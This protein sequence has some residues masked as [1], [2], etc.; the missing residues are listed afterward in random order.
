MAFLL[1]ALLDLS[2]GAFLRGAVDASSDRNPVRCRGDE[3]PSGSQRPAPGRVA[4]DRRDAAAVAVRD[5]GVDRRGFPTRPRSHRLHQHRQ[6]LCD[7]A[8]DSPGPRPA[9][10]R[11]R[12]VR[13]R[14]SARQP[15]RPEFSR[16]HQRAA[17]AAVSEGLPLGRVRRSTTLRLA[18]AEHAPCRTEGLRERLARRRDRRAHRLR[19]PDVALPHVAV[20]VHRSVPAARRG[21][22]GNACR[23]CGLH[24]VRLGPDRDLHVGTVGV[25]PRPG[26]V[27]AGSTGRASRSG[28]SCARTTPTTTST[29]PTTGC[30][31][32]PWAMPAPTCSI[33]SSAS[34][35]SRRSR[36]S[37][38]CSF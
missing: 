14:G 33:T 19:L 34:P 23:R 7:L 30:L 28:P 5:R 35:S 36:P 2:V 11:R 21:N 24:G 20:G 27:H 31:S 18:G 3:A 37:A 32:T 9:H 12:A 8:T 10:Q 17:E 4:R 1:P 25:A 13:Q 16:V 22:R 38:T 26:D 6:R 15:L 29:S